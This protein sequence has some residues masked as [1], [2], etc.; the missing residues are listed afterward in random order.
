MK[1]Y[2]LQGELLSVIG[3]YGNKDGQFNSP[4]RLAFNNKKLLYIVD[5]Y[6]YRIQIFQGNNTFA[7]SFGN[8]GFGPEQF[9]FPFRIAIDCNNNVLVTDYDANCIH[10]F[11]HSG[12]FK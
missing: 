4:R 9:W 3:C 11:S 2:S 8:R 1:K 6:D 7:S 5:R 12:E 10:L